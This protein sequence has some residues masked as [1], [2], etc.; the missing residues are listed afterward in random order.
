[1]ASL[2]T[3]PE[4]APMI[5]ENALLGT[6]HRHLVHGNY[7]IIL[8]MQDDSVFVLRII[9]GGGVV[10][11]VVEVIQ[12]EGGYDCNGDRNRPSA[13]ILQWFAATPTV[14]WRVFFHPAKL[15]ADQEYFY[16]GEYRGR[17]H[18]GGR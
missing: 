2:A 1:M 4:R 18:C 15:L 10:A 9:H 3:M 16:P 5:P 8:R 17:E 13:F 6:G 11:S 14:C 7:R 12:Q